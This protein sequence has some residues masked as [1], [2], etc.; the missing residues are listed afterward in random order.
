MR[1]GIAAFL[2][3]AITSL[4]ATAAAA[5]QAPAAGE[6]GVRLRGIETRPGAQHGAS[7]HRI[8]RVGD[9]AMSETSQEA[10]RRGHRLSVAGGIGGFLIGGLAGGLA[11][12]HFNR[13]SYGVFC[14]GQSDTKLAIGAA[15]GGLAGAALGAWLFRR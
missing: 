3:V 10:M 6:E 14:A 2:V 8:D 12:C 9:V 1:A 5:Q 15:T 4:S 7:V 11:A 13:D